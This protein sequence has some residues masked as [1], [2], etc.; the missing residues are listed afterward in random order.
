MLNTV[1]GAW[2]KY[3]VNWGQ[4]L[5]I[6]GYTRSPHGL[7]TYRRLLQERGPGLRCSRAKRPCASIA[8]ANSGTAAASRD[9]RMPLRQSFPRRGNHVGVKG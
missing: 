5:V 9:A 4:E 6:G 3:R 1:R 7:D 2:A 8:A